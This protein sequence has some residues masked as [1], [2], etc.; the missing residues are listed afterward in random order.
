MYCSWMDSCSAT[1]ESGEAKI[2][3][4]AGLHWDL[5]DGTGLEQT[6]R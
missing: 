4:G 2:E 3:P 5:A 1:A 6:T